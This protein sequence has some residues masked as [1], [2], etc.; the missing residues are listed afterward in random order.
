MTNEEIETV[1]ERAENFNSEDRSNRESDYV[2][3]HGLIGA[4][5][6]AQLHINRLL[7]VVKQLREEG[8]WRPIETAPRDY[9]S[10]FIAWPDWA[11]NPMIVRR[12]GY[13]FF[14]AF[15]DEIDEEPEF[16]HWMSLPEVPDD[17]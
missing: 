6:A 8:T 14:D 5:E 7:A 10:L 9:A 2:T 4:I 13:R 1:I 15:E 11:G 12:D 3:E 16:T 17:N